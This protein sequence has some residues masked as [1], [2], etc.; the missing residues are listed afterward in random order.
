MWSSRLQC[1]IPPYAG[2]VDPHDS[3]PVLRPVPV[4]LEELADALEG[5]PMM[6]GGIL[7]LDT[8]TVWPQFV[9]DSMDLD[10]R[11][12]LYDSIENLLDIDNHGS[13]DA[14]TDMCDFTE[15][16]SDENLTGRLANAMRG[17]GAF[18]RFKDI[19]GER[20]KLLEAFFAFA[21]AQ[22]IERAAAWLAE[23]GYAG[24]LPPRMAAV[25]ETPVPHHTDV[26]G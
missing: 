6:C 4:D 21:D 5:D 18:R 25:T 9:L 7:D 20:P 10:E 24:R 17:R 3:M 14:F 2:G 11:E 8:G 19:L 23:E 12:A 15:T 13:R 1:T 16:L 22:K 26:D